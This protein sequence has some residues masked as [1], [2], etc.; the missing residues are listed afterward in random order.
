MSC[1]YYQ[2]FS[3]LEGK[4]REVMKTKIVW[5]F[6]GEIINA[7][8]SHIQID[9]VVDGFVR[10]TAFYPSCQRF[11]VESGTDV[12]AKAHFEGWCSDDEGGDFTIIKRECHDDRLVYYEQNADN[13]EYVEYL[14]KP[15]PPVRRGV[16]YIV[17]PEVA[18]L[19]PREDFIIP[20][21]SYNPNYVSREGHYTG[22]RVC[23]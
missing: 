13:H 20:I 2:G 12:A 8:N 14:K 18:M 17:T 6:E 11:Y 1:V 21:N 16:Y 22:F 4:E 3:D 23:A 5:P 15:L 7:T 10:G 9:Q 19:F